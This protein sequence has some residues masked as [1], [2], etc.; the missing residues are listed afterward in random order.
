MSHL[1]NVNK[2]VCLNPSKLFYKQKI[3]NLN[4]T[5]WTYENMN[6]VYKLLNYNDSECRI[7]KNMHIRDKFLN[8]GHLVYADFR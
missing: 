7:L 2:T 4:F 5:I 3:I 6:L 8:Y 1:I